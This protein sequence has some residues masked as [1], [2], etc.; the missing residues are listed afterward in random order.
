MSIMTVKRY[1]VR[2]RESAQNWKS[3]GKLNRLNEKRDAVG[4]G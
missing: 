2:I 3:G 1:R 4:R